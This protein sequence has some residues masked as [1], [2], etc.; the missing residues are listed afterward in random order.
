MERQVKEDFTITSGFVYLVAAVVI[1]MLLAVAVLIKEL[2]VF[3]IV[4]SFFLVFFTWQCLRPDQGSSRARPK[5]LLTESGLQR[6][7]TKGSSETIAWTQVANM[8]WVRWYG[9]IVRW[10]EGQPGK[11]GKEFKRESKYDRLYK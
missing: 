1:T 5:W 9:L 3:S 11:R 7:Y 2:R 10:T 4:V 6:I 8:R